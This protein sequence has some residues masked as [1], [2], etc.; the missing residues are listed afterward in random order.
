MKKSAGIL[1]AGLGLAVLTACTGNESDASTE[2]RT[3]SGDDV[4][5][6]TAAG[7]I[8]GDEFY[9]ALVDRFGKTVLQELVT[10]QILEEHYTVSDQDVERE[11]D[12]LKEQIG[13]DFDLWL[14]QQG[15]GNEASFRNMVKVTLLQEEAKADGIEVTD[16][17]IEARYADMNTEVEASHILVDDSD[18][19]EEVKT[20]LD[21]G[22]DFSELAAEY[23]TDPSNSD[24]GGDLGFF[25][26]GMMVP[27]FEEAAFSMDPG[28]ISDPVATQ[29]GYH[30][31]KVTDKRDPGD[32]EESLE[33][34]KREIRNSIVNEKVDPAEAHSR[35]GSLISE[36]L[37]EV[38]I[39]GMDELFDLGEP[40][41]DT[42]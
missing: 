10:I 21:E 42:E 3:V 9:E 29:F 20:L 33:E 30:I 39:D 41:Q 27:E 6:E 11:V 5:A 28:D 37:L 8:T 22:A 25:A 7:V 34:Q 16:E 12:M 17:E 1:A 14:D 26:T 18:T 13:E 32:S 23:S 31:I 4:V 15:Y 38:Q 40:A 2:E 36:E 35:I 24:S 19:A